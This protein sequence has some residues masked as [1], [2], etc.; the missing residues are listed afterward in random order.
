MFSKKKH[1]TDKEQ[2]NVLK[3]RTLHTE[4]YWIQLLSDMRNCA[5][6]AG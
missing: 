6:L 4:Q 3:T 2:T 5:D 1:E